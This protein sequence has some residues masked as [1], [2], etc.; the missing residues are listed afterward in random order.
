MMSMMVVVPVTMIIMR[1]NMIVMIMMLDGRQM[2]HSIYKGINILNMSK[3]HKKILL[4]LPAVV[5]ILSKPTV[6]V[7]LLPSYDTQGKKLMWSL[8]FAVFESH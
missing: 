5:Q 4:L 1:K 6:V 2:V 7:T 8:N 3:K